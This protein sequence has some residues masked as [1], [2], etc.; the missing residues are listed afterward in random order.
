MGHKVFWISCLLTILLLT[1]CKPTVPSQY[2]Q[3]DELEDIL[4]EYHLAEAIAASSL[5][6]NREETSLAY[7]A[8]VLEKYDVT[9]EELDTTL[10]YYTRHTGKLHEIYDNIIKRLNKEALALGGSASGNSQED[11]DENSQNGDTV[12]VWTFGWSAVLTPKEPFHLLSHTISADTSY[13]AG[14][15]MQ[16]KFNSHFIYREN[17]PNSTAV[18]SVKFS[19]D[20]VA[21]YST[22]LQSKTSNVLRVHDKTHQGI[23]EVRM[24][25]VLS[26]LLDNNKIAQETQLLVLTNIRLLRIRSSKDAPP[27]NPEEHD[28]NQPLQLIG[29]QEN[30]H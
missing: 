26:K 21:S 30:I 10:V 17:F 3:P 8:A 22:R 4:Y 2:I 24:Y 16:L 9:Q 6:D 7:K 29:G 5:S 14:D 12:N 19:N 13:H 28:E 23:K 18:L 15:M 27:G 1:G 11:W 25:V 20:S